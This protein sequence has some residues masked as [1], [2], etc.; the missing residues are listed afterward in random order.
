V[1]L[2]VRAPSI[3]REGG[4]SV[5]LLV[6]GR[7]LE[8]ERE[9]TVCATWNHRWNRDMPGSHWAKCEEI[10]VNKSSLTESTFGLCLLSLTKTHTHRHIHK[11][12]HIQSCGRSCSMALTLSTTHWSNRGAPSVRD[13]LLLSAPLSTTGS[14]SCLWPLN[15]KTPPSDNLTWNRM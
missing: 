2:C 5:W 4:V 8:V 9:M 14:H 12:T 11:V 3:G 13:S 7:P 1:T 15:S 10:S 6:S